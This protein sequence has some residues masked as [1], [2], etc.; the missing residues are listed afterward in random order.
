LNFFFSIFQNLAR[1][2]FFN[3]YTNEIKLGILVLL[4]PPFL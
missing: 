1:Y 2:I 3:Y 4:E